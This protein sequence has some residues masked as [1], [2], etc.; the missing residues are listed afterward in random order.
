MRVSKLL[1]GSV[2]MK[3]K[4]LANRRLRCASQDLD[5]AIMCFALELALPYQVH[6]HKNL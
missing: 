5:A 3:K 6:R 4:D 2:H 1:I